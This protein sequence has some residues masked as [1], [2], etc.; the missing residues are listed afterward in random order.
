MADQANKTDPLTVQKMWLHKT[1]I[2]FM[3]FMFGALIV[4]G[5]GSLSKRPDIQI[6]GHDNVV[7]YINFKI[8]GDMTMPE[9]KELTPTQKLKIANEI[10]D[11]LDDKCRALD[12]FSEPEILLLA[13]YARTPVNERQAQAFNVAT[14]M[15]EDM[16]DKVRNVINGALEDGDDYLQFRKQLQQELVAIAADQPTR[17]RRA[18]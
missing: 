15:Q 4:F 3:A 12:C 16:L 13:F 8:E 14:L 11:L 5:I 1:F 2:Y 18:R 7:L 6:T 10:N 9:I 17:A